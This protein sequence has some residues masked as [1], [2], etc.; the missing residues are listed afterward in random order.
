MQL[1]RKWLRR[2]FGALLTGIAFCLALPGC[3]AG[4][5]TKLKP[6]A[7]SLRES[8][9]T[10]PKIVIWEAVLKST[11]DNGALEFEIPPVVDGPDGSKCQLGFSCDAKEIQAW[12][13][14]PIGSA[15]RF[16]A[17]WNGITYR[18]T[19]LVNPDGSTAPAPFDFVVS[20]EG[21]H[22]IK[23]L[24]DPKP[25]TSPPTVAGRVDLAPVATEMS[26]P[27]KGITAKDPRE[28]RK[29]QRPEEAS[30][31]PKVTH[32]LKLE[33]IWFWKL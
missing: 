3:S 16:E 27:S 19:N 21:A 14:I 7:D 9:S 24:Y 8:I 29:S 26:P 28:Q 13:S 25:K 10:G 1:K 6:L 32:A 12:R 11:G 4:D 20:L 18:I 5:S 2:R 22:V 31:H 30:Q 15:V 23:V 17:K 33:P